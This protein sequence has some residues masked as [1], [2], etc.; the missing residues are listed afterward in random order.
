MR[1]HHRGICDPRAIAQDQFNIAVFF[2]ET[3]KARDQPAGAKNGTNSKR[4]NLSR[5]TDAFFNLRSDVIKRPGH[6]S[7]ERTPLIRKNHRTRLANKQLA[8]PIPFQLA[9]LVADRCCTHA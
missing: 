1:C 3:R 8:P 2:T 6:H 7:A 5:W 9:D 4:Y